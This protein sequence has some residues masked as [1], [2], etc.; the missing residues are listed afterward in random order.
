MPDSLI[1]RGEGSDYNEPPKNCQYEMPYLITKMR[2]A[3]F[4]K[5]PWIAIPM[6]DDV[7][8]YVSISDG[9]LTKENSAA[10]LNEW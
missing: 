3:L 5:H 4:F 7:L 6:L 1:L 9:A 8:C 10:H 2:G